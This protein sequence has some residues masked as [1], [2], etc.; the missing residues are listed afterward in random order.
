MASSR[1]KNGRPIVVVTGMGV[2]TSLGAGKADNWAKLTAGESGI[3][4]ITRFA[5]EGLKTTIA[6][7]VDFIPVE[8]FCSTDLGERMAAMVAEEAITEAGIGRKGDFPGPLF[9]AVAPVEIE[10]PHRDVL[11]AASGANDAVGYD[12]LL[13]ASASGRFHAIH[14][15][16]LFGSVAEHLA[17]QFGT[18]GSP[19]SV[20]TACASGASAIQLGVEA[21]R[22]GEAEAALCIGTD[23]SVNPEALIRFSLLSALSTSNNPP[24]SAA[25]PFAKNRDGFVMAEGAA[26]L[27]LES[28]NPPSRAARTSSA[29]SPVAARWRTRSTAPARAP[30][31]NRSSDASAAPS[32]MPGSRP[33]TS[34]TSTRTAPAPPRTT[35]WNISAWRRCLESG[36]N[37]FRF[38]RTS[39]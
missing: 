33:R 10:W 25:K 37:G 21:I 38:P 11:A 31:V 19:I 20:S 27:V 13:R 16:C 22:R 35:R 39:R 32:R 12:D 15:R 28:Y 29:F 6:G 23:G 14:E 24:E 3:H 5:N 18:K 8:P 1:D 36:P 9:L 30:T 34:T 2:I 7:S 4:R 26:A 17:D